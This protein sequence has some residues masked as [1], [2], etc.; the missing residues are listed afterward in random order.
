MAVQLRA[1][2]RRPS[3]LRL[4]P[5]GARDRR[6]RHAQP[7]SRRVK[8]N[9]AW[10]ARTRQVTVNMIICGVDVA[11]HELVAALEDG[12]QLGGF[13]NNAEGIGLLAEA[14]RQAQVGLVVMEATGGHER[15]AV[16]LLA[17]AGLGVAVADP[18]RVRL[19]AQAITGP[20]KTDQIDA[21]MIAAFA[22]VRGLQ[23][24]ALPSPGQQRLTRLVRRLG[25][26]TADL[27]AHKNRLAACDEAEIA[28]SLNRVMDVLRREAR[29]LE[30]EVASLI[31]DDPLW[32]ALAA[33]F[34]TVKGVAGRTIA[35]L[36]ADLPEIGTYSGKAI[37]KLCGLAPI[38][39]DSGQRRGRRTTGGGRADVRSILFLVA[40]IAARF[41]NGL[42][43]FHHRLSAAGK[44]LMV[45]RIA[46]AR[47]LLVI[48]NAKARDART[49]LNYA[50]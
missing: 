15:K 1:R 37:A 32:A 11:K 49:A 36:M 26:V 24:M 34:A 43:D 25:Q 3:A 14:L 38:A 44:P 18:R 50:T 28:A 16:L 10:A 40:R 2:R 29:S 17:A 35:R 30:G 46:L 8:A 48:L 33:E 21:V 19:F 31:D 6:R 47:K 4:Q 41:H 27:S 9:P 42:R 39:N 13:G 22:R 12:R 7:N 23:P 45:I 5:W 20:E